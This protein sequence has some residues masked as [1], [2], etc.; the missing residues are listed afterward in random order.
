VALDPEFKDAHL[1]LGV[2]LARQGRIDEAVTH[3]Q[4]AVALDPGFTEAQNDLKRALGI[5]AAKS[6]R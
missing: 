5:Q 1:N 2:I 4:A 6:A 3:F